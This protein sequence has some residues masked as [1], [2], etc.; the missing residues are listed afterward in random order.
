MPPG[1][2]RKYRK[3]PRSADLGYFRYFRYGPAGQPPPAPAGH[4]RE[5]PTPP[6]PLQ[7]PLQAVHTGKWV[8]LRLDI[9]ATQRNGPAAPL[10]SRASEHRAR[11]DPRRGE[12]ARFVA[13][14]LEWT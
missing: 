14:V 7:R 10:P 4:S 9:H 1:P 13:K 8:A 12:N 6:P 5:L 11:R 3:Y 2:Y